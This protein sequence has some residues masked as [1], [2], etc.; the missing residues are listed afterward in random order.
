MRSCT[1]LCRLSVLVVLMCLVPVAAAQ[2]LP[3]DKLVKHLI[4]EDPSDPKSAVTFEIALT[5]EAVERD[6]DSVR[7][8]VEQVEIREK[9]TGGGSDT[10]WASDAPDVD[11]DSGDWWVDHDDADDPTNEDFVRPPLIEGVADPVEATDDDLEFYLQGLSYTPPPGGPPWD[12][13]GA[14]GYEFL[15][16]GDMEPIAE[17]PDEPVEVPPVERPP[18]GN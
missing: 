14:I 9:A 13:T 15:I 1:N 7:W 8:S 3:S 10:V 18:V 6:G 11:T 16:V 2:G 4:H 5:L 17:D 12:A